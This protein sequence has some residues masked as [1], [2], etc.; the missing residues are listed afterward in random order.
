M[1]PDYTHDPIGHF[2][3]GAGGLR[4]TGLPRVTFRT[5]LHPPL[6]ALDFYN[7]FLLFAPSAHGWVYWARSSRGEAKFNDPVYETGPLIPLPPE[8]AHT[9]LFPFY[10][11]TSTL[12]GTL[13]YIESFWD[14][15]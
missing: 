1:D 13:L 6:L 5:R 7:L 12:G 10:R 3:W 11:K 9:L 4:V 8:S 14:A 2:G 15:L